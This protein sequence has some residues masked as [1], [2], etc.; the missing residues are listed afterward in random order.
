LRHGIIT[1]RLTG[2]D[3]AL[4][5]PEELYGFP[6]NKTCEWLGGEY[7]KEAAGR[8]ASRKS[9][10]GFST[11][12]GDFACERCELAG[13]NANR[14]VDVCAYEYFSASQKKTLTRHH[15]ALFLP[16]TSSGSRN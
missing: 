10:S 12:G 7:L 14:F 8:A 3:V 2:R 13:G 5:S 16:S 1:F 9:D 4:V 15:R 6:W 11:L